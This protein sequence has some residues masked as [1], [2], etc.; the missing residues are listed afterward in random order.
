MAEAYSHEVSSCGFWSSDEDAAFYAYA[1]PE[2]AGFATRPRLPDGAF[3]D[4]GIGNFVL[5]LEVVRAADDPDHLV[6]DFLQRTYDAAA[7]LAGWDRA[8]LE[9]H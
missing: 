9:R 2:P 4:A 8:V 7:D 5:P 1:F 3:Y 6:L